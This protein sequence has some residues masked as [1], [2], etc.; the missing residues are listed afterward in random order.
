MHR[1]INREAIFGDDVDRHMFLACLDTAT[2]RYGVAVHVFA[3]MTNHYHLLVTPSRDQ[4]LARA[5]RG[6]GIRYT[7][8]YNRKYGRIGTLWTGRY[9]G[10]PIC[11]DHYWMTCLRYIELNP[12]RAKMVGRPE[13]Y[14]WSTYRT[15]ALGEPHH[16]IVH[17]DRYRALGANAEERQMAYRA[18]CNEPLTEAELVHQRLGPEDFL[19][20]ASADPVLSTALA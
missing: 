4:A 2:S 1:G 9:R 7:L 6:L 15:Y 20:K 17:H 3:L 18:L 10:I 16:W 14:R 19:P 5:M 13:D 8:Y 11:D 12:V